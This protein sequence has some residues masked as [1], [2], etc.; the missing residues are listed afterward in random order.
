VNADVLLLAVL[1][2][3]ALVALWADSRFPRALPKRRGVLL[4]HLF[5]SLAALQAAPSLMKLEPGVGNSALPATCA[6][7]G[8][9]FP[10]LIYAF[11]SAI[12]VIRAVQGVLA[13]G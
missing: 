2:G 3:A 10:A 9:F 8:L 12:W 4:I 1:A 6:L 5:A 13:R 7:L 11:L